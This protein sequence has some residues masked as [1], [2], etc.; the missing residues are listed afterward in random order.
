MQHNLD[1]LA[2]HIT[3][4]VIPL[5]LLKVSQDAILYHLPRALSRWLGCCSSYTHSYF[6][7]GHSFANLHRT[8]SPPLTLSPSVFQGTFEQAS[9]P[10]LSLPCILFKTNLAVKQRPKQYLLIPITASNACKSLSSAQSNKQQR[11]PHAPRD[12]LPKQ[13]RRVHARHHQRWPPR[14]RPSH[15]EQNP[16]RPIQRQ[17]PLDSSRLDLSRPAP[18]FRFR[19]ILCASSI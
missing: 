4:L 16:L 13:Q 1:I 5:S 11:L 14:H 8:V 15:P 2:E 9:D 6:F 7:Y 10:T 17:R 19:P 3:Y 18:L 12:R